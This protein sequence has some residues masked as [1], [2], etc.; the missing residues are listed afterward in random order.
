MRKLITIFTILTLILPCRLAAQKGPE[1]RITGTVVDDKGEAVIGAAVYR[2]SDKTC[3]TVVDLDGN[4]SMVVPRGVSMCVA[5]MGF[6]DYLFTADG[7]GPFKIVM[8]D[9]YETI[10]GTVVVGYGTQKKESLV[11]SISSVTSESLEK[12]GTMDITTAL[13]GNVV[14]LTTLSH[15]G[16]PGANT[17]E[18]FIRGLSSW[19]GSEPLVMVDG[20]ERSFSEIDPH[21]VASISVLKDASATAVFGAKGANGVILVTTKTGEVSKPKFSANVTFGMDF[22]TMIPEHISSATTASMLNVARKNAQSWSELYPDS[23]IA[24]YANPTT[25]LDAIRYCDTDWFKEVMKTMAP[26]LTANTTASGGTQK[27]KYFVSFGL[28]HQTSVIRTFRDS[29]GKGFSYDRFNFRTNFD[30]SPSRSTLVSIRFGGNVSMRTVPTGAGGNRSEN[31]FFGYM[32]G[33]SP[34]MY[35]AYYPEWMLE[36]VPDTDYPDASGIRYA[37]KNNAYY[38]NVISELSTGAY[39]K[40]AGTQIFSDIVIDQKLDFLT[41]GLSLKGTA[42]LTT[43]TSR[44]AEQIS[45]SIPLY[46]LD[47]NIYDSSDMNPWKEINS[48]TDVGEVLEE[49]KPVVQVGTSLSSHTYNMYLEASLNYQR[50]FGDHDL[51]GLVLYQQRQN[52]TN[53]DFPYRTMGF[54]SRVTY[55]Y[56]G[57]YLIEGNVGYTGSEQFSPRNRFGLFPSIAVGFVPSRYNS[58]KAAMPA[59]SKFKVRFSDGLVGNDRTSQRWLY[60]SSYSRQNNVIVE[61]YAANF[62]AKW[63]TARKRD[64]GLEFGF[65]KDRLT[66]VADL[67]SEHRTDMLVNPVVTVLTG[68]SFKPRNDGEMKKHGLELELGWRNKLDSGL[69]YYVKG[70]FSIYENRIVKYADALYSPE[71][72]KTAGK[73][74]GGQTNG[75]EAVDTGYFVDVDDIHGYSAYSDDW[76]NLFIGAYKYNDFN[77]DGKIDINDLHAIEGTQYAPISGSLHFG[78]DWRGFDF[79]VIFNGVMGNYVNYNSTWEVEFSKGDLRVNK[80]Q[81]DYWTPDN[82]DANHASLTFGSSSG[83]P[84]YTWAGGDP[85][86]GYVMALQDRIWRKADYVN[87][88]EMYLGY[89]F[90]KKALGNSGLPAL[91][92]FATGNNLFTITNLEEGDPKCPNLSGGFYPNMLLVKIGVKVQF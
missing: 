54:V 29:E 84:M 21:E 9:A 13:S 49:N 51:S 34:M 81:L 10:E 73:A 1:V 79:H 5:S 25:R 28:D 56:N 31:A 80:T 8:K 6:E 85:V 87:L 60:Y 40:T 77:A 64:L 12:S 70:M 2:T 50:K 4:F 47:W 42:S 69:G 35:P 14:G 82:P 66:L 78:F 27:F 32:Y 63:E 17:Q 23:I 91:S 71:Y 20:V 55:N 37:A 52:T 89:T 68:T 30:Y 58:W 3:G 41:Q 76:N 15:G 46:V 53:A 65:F 38:A 62:D 61:D 57:I 22:P 45:K 86:S 59:W 75:I 92:L 24:K 48:S 39:S 16:A 19:N 11:G 83:H 67:Y 36:E 44:S 74:Y 33:A 43:T 88:K 7:P 26:S 18:I 72:Q 90:D